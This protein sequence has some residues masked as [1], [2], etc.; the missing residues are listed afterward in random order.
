MSTPNLAGHPPAGESRLPIDPAAL[1]ELLQT[2]NAAADRLQQS[3]DRLQQRV[4][5]LSRELE[6]KN[7]ELETQRRLAVL[8]EM[9][10]C[11]AHEI[12]NPLGG[13]GLYAGLLQ[14]EVAPIPDQARLCERILTGVQNLN[15]LVEDILTYTGGLHPRVE[16]VRLE[17]IL[18][19]AVSFCL[20]R[21][22]AKQVTIVRHPNPVDARVLADAGM[23]VRVFLNLIINAIQAVDPG[24]RVELTTEVGAAATVRVRDNGPGIHAEALPRLFTPFYTG[25]SRGTGLGLAIASRIVESHRGRIEGRNAPDGGAEFTVTLPLAG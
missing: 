10:A 11:L 1:A 3:H 12:R 15:A 6:Q 2:F 13:I 8:G 4:A 18:D 25:K 20:D 14:R 22:G 7:Q 16:S 21:I 19:E 24:G 5:E 17:A 9:A 23:L